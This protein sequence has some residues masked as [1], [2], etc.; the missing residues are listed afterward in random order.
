MCLLSKEETK[1]LKLDKMPQEDIKIEFQ[2]G[3]LLV[4]APEDSVVPLARWC[5]FDKRVGCWRAEGARYAEIITHL[6]R[7]KIP[8]RDTAKAYS[9]LPLRLLENRQP[10]DYQREALEA[11]AASGRRG[12][13][14]LPTG[15][16]KSFV[17]QLAMAQVC[18]STLVVVP[19]IDLMTQWAGQLEKAFGIEVGMLGG[20]SKEVRDICVSTYDSA[21]LMMDSIGSRFGLLVVDECHHLP[22]M[23][24]RQLA[25][26]AIAPFRLGL[27]A[28][29]EREDGEEQVLNELLG[30]ICYRKDIDEMDARVLAPYTTQRICV[31]LD[32]DEMEA[33]WVNRQVYVD[34]LHRNGINVSTPQGWSQFVIACSRLPGGREALKGFFAQRRIAMGGRAKLRAVWKILCE[35]RNSR[36]IIFT[37]DNNTA[38]SIGERFRLPVLTHHTKAAER[39]D[40]LDAFRHGDYPCLVTSKVL[41]EGVDVPEAE[42]GIV[43]SGSGSTREH[44][45]RLGRI[46]RPSPGKNAILYE[47]ISLGTSEWGTSDRRRRNRAY[48]RFDSM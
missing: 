36:I 22:G 44:V 5:V 30:P 18:R 11:W 10:R 32:A 37:A 38:Y 28:T 47:L 2:D 33:Y 34:F 3:T 19:T 20:G 35:H 29:P 26:D 46:L 25:R 7:E 48:E 31:E 43:V 12:V 1:K 6:F 42:V 13:V 41:N 17:A 16:G 14:V 39:K 21:V 15:T 24:Y 40:F 27:S 8:Y 45:Q 4:R 9:V 23:C